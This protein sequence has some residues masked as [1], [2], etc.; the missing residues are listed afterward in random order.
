MLKKTSSSLPS[1]I[2]IY[3]YDFKLTVSD[4]NM[5]VT[6]CS[7]KLY[8]RAYAYTHTNELP[9]R[10]H[11][12]KLALTSLS[13]WNHTGCRQWGKIPICELNLGPLV[14]LIWAWTTSPFEHKNTGPYSQGCRGTM[15]LTPK[16]VK[17]HFWPKIWVR[18]LGPKGEFLEVLQPPSP[19]HQS[20]LANRPA[21]LLIITA[22][23][24]N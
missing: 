20:I 24:I 6:G 16:S 2:Y 7:I 22:A 17:V 18:G 5:R 13:P 12:H 3:L 10:R 1:Y 8:S 23:I 14:C 11:N 19:H 4:V 21:R 9:A 15:Y